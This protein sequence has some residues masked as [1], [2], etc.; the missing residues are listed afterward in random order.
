MTIIIKNF[1][2]LSHFHV[3]IFIFYHH[4]KKKKILGPETEK[5]PPKKGKR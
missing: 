1:C 4:E 2:F 5:I 3:H